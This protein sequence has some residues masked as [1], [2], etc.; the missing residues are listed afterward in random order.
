MNA[1]SDNSS[2]MD[3]FSGNPVFSHEEFV[4]AR[5]TATGA[6]PHTTN[7]LLA[8]HLAAGHLVRVRRGLYATVPRGVRPDAARVDPYLLATKL[9]DDAVV[10]YHAA[11]QYHGK[12]YSLWNRY[13]Y[14]TRHRARPLQFRESQFL[15]VQLPVAVRSLPDIGAGVVEQRHAGGRVRVTTL[16]RTLVDVLDAPEHGG[17]WEEAWRSLESV[18]FFDLD[19][20]VACAV[21]LGSALTVAR[22]GFFLAQHREV[23][24]VDDGHYA[25]LR[26]HAPAQPRYL[27]RRREP[28]KLISPWNLVV[29]ERVLQRSWAEVS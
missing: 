28:G 22:V 4:T 29:P 26:A 13:T 1:R 14:L 16:E 18:E 12:A 17:G 25:Q 8:H 20:V 7:N 6:S 2:A 10:A 9:T 24:M 21:K 23:L 19:A 3:F 15:P 27:D 5:A 11:L